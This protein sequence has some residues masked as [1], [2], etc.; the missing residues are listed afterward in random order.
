EALVVVP[1]IFRR[2]HT[3][4]DEDHVRIERHALRLRLIAADDVL[5]KLQRAERRAV[6]GEREG[7]LLALG[8]EAE[9]G[10]FLKIRS[11]VAR[12]FESEHLELRGDV[13]RGQRVASRTGAA[14]F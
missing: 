10:H 3:V 14:A 9:E 1:L 11:A 2:R 13:A 6:P 7:R 4:A 12:R 8:G 5:P